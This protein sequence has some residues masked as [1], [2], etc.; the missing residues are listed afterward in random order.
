MSPG[1]GPAFLSALVNRAPLSLRTALA[2]NSSVIRRPKFRLPAICS[3]GVFLMSLSLSPAQTPPAPAAANASP[4]DALSQKYNAGMEAFNKGDYAAAAANMQ[5]ILG[6]VTEDSQLDSVYYTLGAAQYNLH[7]FGPAIESLRKFVQKYPKSP[8]IDDVTLFIGQAQVQMKDYEG[9]SKT[10]A[11][12]QNKPAV[13]EQVLLLL[14]Q[15]AKDAG[16][17]DA[18][19]AILRKL[20]DGGVHSIETANGMMLLAD[21]YAQ[22]GETDKAITL[23]KAMRE[24]TGQLDNI[25]RLNAMAVEQGDALLK[26][27]KP[28]QA[29]ASYQLVQP[30][31][32]VIRLQKARI[33]AMEAKVAQNLEAVRADPQRAQEI[34]VT[35]G[36]LRN[37][38][39][40]AKA[41][42]E[43]FEKTPDFAGPFWLRV[44]QAYYGMD[45]KWEAATVYDELLRREPTSAERESALFG[46]VVTSA[47]LNRGLITRDL[48]QQYLKEFPK[49]A[50]AN[51][52]G[53]LLGA[54]ALQSGDTEAAVKYFGLMLETQT[55][56]AYREQIS[57]LLGNAHFSL[58]DFDKAKADY[59]KYLETY[60]KGQNVEEAV[61]RT[62]LAALFAGKY[63]DAIK[64]INDYIRKYPTGNFLAD[65]KYRLAVCQYAASDY[66]KV[67]KDCDAWLKEFPGDALRG[68]VLALKGDALAPLPGREEEAI[69]AYIASLNAAGTE[70]VLTHSLTEGA[71]LLQ[72]RGDWEKLDK[73]L[74]EFVDAN[75]TSPV[76]VPV[77][78]WI[79]KAKTK[80]GK[81]DEARE[82][83]AGVI[84]KNIKDPNQAAVEQL[85]TQLAL[86]TAKRRPATTADPA[87]TPV[88]AAVALV[89]ATRDLESL[90]GDATVSPTAQARVLFAKS[91]VARLRKDPVEQEKNLAA[92]AELPPGKLSPLL[93][94]QVGDYLLAKG[95]IDKADV[96]FKQ[97]LESYPKS[98]YLDFAYNGFGEIAYRKKNYP[99]ALGF[100]TDAIGKAGATMKLKEAQK[101]FEQ[102]AS[103]REWRGEST[104]YSVYSLGEIE[105]KK[106]KL[107]EAIAYYQRVYVAYRKYLPWVAKAYLRSAE[108]FE[109][110][111]K[112]EE[113]V[114]TYRE[115][116]Y[117]KAL[118]DFPEYAEARTKLDALGTP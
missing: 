9:A 27:G 74:T 44:G 79:A 42:L 46:L 18:A 29:L 94:A 82:V 1:N 115:M 63:E 47:E 65:A 107:P 116:L 67:V 57:F 60:P 84:K 14:G 5:E 23:L 77:A 3:L 28:D 54:T 53:Y 112:K 49:G 20:T 16:K 78:Y 48:A 24:N 104:A 15:A 100:F 7:Q 102:V 21:I 4:Q 11:A 70:E 43:A 80:E 110:L 51:T 89:Q 75:P 95:Q 45:R 83:I 52:V 105:E 114:K 85:I 33:A 76:I 13:R 98:D 10:L 69:D 35:N 32:E 66:E 55:D 36:Q 56:S 58:G 30:Q 71:K 39:A 81:P 109:K 96:F 88:P 99:A 92:I 50:N 2:E 118:A 113:A 59:T 117:N 40:Q 97:L 93:L 68:E 90:L 91:E 8:K 87:A 37:A 31:S 19:I 103:T 101:L 111:G 108:C 41:Q 86:L 64:G 61:Y 62:A 72:K 22:T 12:L 38:V 34:S 25:V 26:A 73:T 6:A 17:T 106:G